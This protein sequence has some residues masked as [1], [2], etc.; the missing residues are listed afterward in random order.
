MFEFPPHFPIALELRTQWDP[1]QLF[2][3]WA[4][5]YLYGTI[6]IIEMPIMLARERDEWKTA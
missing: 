5:Q 2:I 3:D 4:F 6:I 1:G